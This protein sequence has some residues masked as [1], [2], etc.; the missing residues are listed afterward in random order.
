LEK[1]PSAPPLEKNPFDAQA[2]SMDSCV[3]LARS[4]MQK[5]FAG[6]AT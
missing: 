6:R 1:S 4:A 2:N 3:K 5:E